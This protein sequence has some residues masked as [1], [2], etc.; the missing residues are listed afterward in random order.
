MMY[1]ECETCLICFNRRISKGQ[2]QQVTTI[3]NSI[4]LSSDAFV[5]Q[6]RMMS[7]FAMEVSICMLDPKTPVLHV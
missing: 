5:F 3:S 6:L 1:V 7:K 4:C 2:E